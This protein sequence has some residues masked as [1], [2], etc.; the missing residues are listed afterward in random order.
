MVLPRE[1][2]AKCQTIPCKSVNVDHGRLV[3]R[4]GKR[5]IAVDFYHEYVRQMD[6]LDYIKK[7]TSL[8]EQFDETDPIKFW[9]DFW[10][11]LYVDKMKEQD[12]ATSYNSLTK[13]EILDLDIILI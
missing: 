5:D 11:N 8:D 7:M 12:Y 2:V 10:T 4:E 9:E 1:Y 3:M 6:S 13:G